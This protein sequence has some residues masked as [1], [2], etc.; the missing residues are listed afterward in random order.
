MFNFVSHRPD[1]ASGR[2]DCLA[3][4]ARSNRLERRT[5]L[6]ARDLAHYKVDIAAL[7]E[8]RFSKQGQLEEDWFNDND[9]AISNLIAEKIRL[10]KT[11]VDRPTDH[12]KPA[13]YSSRRLVLQRLREMQDVW[14]V[15]KAEEIQWF[16]D[17]NEWKSVFSAIKAVYSPPTKG[18]APFLSAD[19]SVPLTEKTRILQ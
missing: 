15:R 18:T 5:T 17:S 16:T 4:V 2:S 8:T 7:S 3:S 9:A 10:H 6:A 12:N 1:P 13:F 11:Y 19:G 14:T